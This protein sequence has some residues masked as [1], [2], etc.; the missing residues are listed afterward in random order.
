[1]NVRL[2]ETGASEDGLVLSDLPV[3][4][5]SGPDADLRLDDPDVD[6]YHCM[7]DQVD[8]TPVVFDLVSR[9]GTMV[10]GRRVDQW[11]LRPGDELTIGSTRLV[12]SASA[13]PVRPLLGGPA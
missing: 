12:I 2:T 8:G 10:N 4:V 11:P 1:M 9:T 6:A 5:G 7:I 3:I 13:P